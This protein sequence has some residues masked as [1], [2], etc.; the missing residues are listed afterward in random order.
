MDI[1]FYNYKRLLKG[2]TSRNI[3]KTPWGGEVFSSETLTEVK[4]NN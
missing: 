1:E 3:F 2:D 4:K